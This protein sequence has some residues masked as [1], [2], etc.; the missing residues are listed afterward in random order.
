MRQVILRAAIALIMAGP[1]MSAWARDLTPPEQRGR[2]LYREGVTADGTSVTAVLAHGSLQLAG[3]RVACASCHGSDGLGR[4][5][6]GV[7]PSNITWANLTKPYGLTHDNGRSHPPYTADAVVAAIT[8]GVDPAGNTL[9][10]AMPRYTLDERAGADL[11]AYLQR[12]GSD[13]DQGV[14]EK[15]IVVATVVPT[16]GRLADNGDVVG[17]LLSAYFDRVNGDGGIYSRHIVLKTAAFDSSGSAVD[18]LRR[19][20]SETD[21]FAVVAPVVLGQEEA[22]V[23][24]AESSALPVVGPLAQYR[25]S[26]AERQR[27][28]F[29]LTAGLEDQA[30]ALAKYA[31]SELAPIDPKVAILWSENGAGSGIGDAIRQQ[32][33]NAEWAPMLSLPLTAT[34]AIADVASQLRV[35]GVNIIFYDGG[36]DRLVELAQ[37]TARAEWRPAILVV[38]QPL[39]RESF[40]RLREL[41][42]R[43]FVAYPLLGSD[44]SPDALAGLRSLQAANAVPAQHLP[45]QVAA[46]AAGRVLIEGLKRSGRDLTRAKFVATLAALQN[47]ETGLMPPISFGP[48]RRT[49]VRGAHIVPLGHGPNEPEGVWVSLE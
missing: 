9:D 31:Q 41:D 6:A 47:F 16:G 46:L 23:E 38:G 3:R 5:D 7:V 40:V 43:V 37:E 8:A 30:R 44:Q 20:M 24:F 25:R 17:R 28:T 11:V 36:P 32:G 45:M 12:L 4:P 26:A 34:T 13:R 39:T 22:L 19:L 29:H 49:A 1:V 35:V 48:N 18:A 33:P 14:G 2:Q 15:E 10:P 21:V 27:F 42:A